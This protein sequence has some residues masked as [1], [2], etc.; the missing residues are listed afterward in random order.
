MP[1][2]EMVP[3]LYCPYINVLQS[4]D[5]AIISKE[6]GTGNQLRSPFYVGTGKLEK[7]CVEDID[8]LEY[9]WQP[10]R[11]WW[12][13]VRTGSGIE[14]FSPSRFEIPVEHKTIRV[15][16]TSDDIRFVGEHYQQPMSVTLTGPGPWVIVFRN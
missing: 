5:K 13:R 9:H 8:I 3:S 10:T 14:E 1:A 11:S 2:S 15:M 12:Q 6:V 4:A 7:G 16:L